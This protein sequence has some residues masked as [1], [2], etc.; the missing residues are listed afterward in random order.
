[1]MMNSL[2][3]NIFEFSSEENTKID[4]LDAPNVVEAKIDSA[5]CPKISSG[6]E[7][8]V[9]AFYKHVVFPIIGQVFLINYFTN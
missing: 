4:L 5:I 9:L 6:V 3:K 1:M 2:I 8:G 7:N